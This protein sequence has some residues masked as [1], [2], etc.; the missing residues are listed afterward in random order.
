MTLPG[1]DTAAARGDNL[2][3][4]G[5][6]GAGKSAVGQAAA[7]RLRRP[8]ADTDVWVCEPVGQSIRAIF[9]TRGEAV[10]RQMERDAVHEAACC[11]GYV[12]SVGGGAVLRA[13]NRAALRRAGWCVWLTAPAA[14]LHRRLAADPSTFAGR[15][16]L[17]AADALAEIEQLLSERA[18]LYAEVADAQVETGGRTI[19][20]VVEA[21]LR[22]WPQRPPGL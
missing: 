5:P 6:R 14:E 18:A 13:D 15:P 11:R 12:I 21:V 7:L 9:E 19:D 3:L 22:S 20:E 17:T 10:F 2:V 8:W 1:A 16:P 4:I